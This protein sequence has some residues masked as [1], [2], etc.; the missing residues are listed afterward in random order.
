MWEKRFWESNFPFL[1]MK[2]ENQKKSETI[3]SQ[4]NSCIEKLK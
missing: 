1:T 4:E 2:Y 3:G